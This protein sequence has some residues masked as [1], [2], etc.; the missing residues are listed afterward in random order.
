MAAP[1]RTRSIAKEDFPDAPEW[2][3]KLAETL[4]PFLTDTGNALSG[5]LSLT[6]NVACA[7]NTFKFTMPATATDIPAYA[8]AKNAVLAQ[9][10]GD[11]ATVTVNF[12]TTVLDSHSA[13]TNPTTAWRWT[14]PQDGIYAVSS[15]VCML[16][17]AGAAVGDFRTYIGKNGATHAGNIAAGLTSYFTSV[18]NATM[19]LVEGDYIQIYAYQDSDGSKNIINDADFTHVSI[20]Q[21]SGHVPGAASCFP[22]T[23]KATIKGSPFKPKAVLIGSLRDTQTG[24]THNAGTPSWEWD[25]TQSVRITNIPGLTYGREY[26]VTFLTF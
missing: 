14:C 7:V 3:T 5:R 21:V 4:N 8:R 20:H 11:T 17:G 6:D 19:S 18:I 26:E 13:I 9:A 2:F 25:G 24:A 15:H 10:V 1:P 16:F 22:L 12:G 23:F